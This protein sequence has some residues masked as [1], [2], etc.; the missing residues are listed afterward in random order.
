MKI[1]SED[2]LSFAIRY[3]KQINESSLNKIEMLKCLNEIKQIKYDNDKNNYIF[4]TFE[5]EDIILNETEVIKLIG[6]WKCDKPKINNWARYCSS[7][8]PYYFN[9]DNLKKIFIGVI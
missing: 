6:C 4:R 1:E 9:T 7:K 8:C 2:D 3:T 5:G